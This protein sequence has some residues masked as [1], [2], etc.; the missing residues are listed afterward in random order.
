MKKICHSML[1]LTELS[2]AYQKFI[3]VNRHVFFHFRIQEAKV[4]EDRGKYKQ[5]EFCNMRAFL[6]PLDK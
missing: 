5:T 4:L 6:T 2:F 1:E 3:D